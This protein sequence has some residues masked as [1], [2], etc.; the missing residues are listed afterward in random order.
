MRR[1]RCARDYV[2]KRNYADALLKEEQTF[3][4]ACRYR[5]SEARRA[6]NL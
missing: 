3:H 2:K 1:S 5:G 6:A 4:D